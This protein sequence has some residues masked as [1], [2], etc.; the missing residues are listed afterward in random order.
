MLLFSPFV[1]CEQFHRQA[2]QCMHFSRSKAGTA[3]SPVVIACP[4]HI[5][6]QVRA[7]QRWHNCGVDKDHVIG[8]AG[9]GLHLAAHQQR[10][11]V[12][13]QQLAVEGNRRPAAG[14]HEHIVKRSDFRRQPAASAP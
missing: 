6:M 5:S 2:P 1:V 4:E 10:V 9:G 3:C 7:P 8:V 14:V 13:D 11:L 12:R